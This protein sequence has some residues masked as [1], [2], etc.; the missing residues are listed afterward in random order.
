VVCFGQCT[1]IRPGPRRVSRD[2]VSAILSTFLVSVPIAAMNEP[3][4]PPVNPS[5]RRFLNI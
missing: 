1:E 5:L 3:S 2:N 4:F